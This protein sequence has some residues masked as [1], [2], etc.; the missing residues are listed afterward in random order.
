MAHPMNINK[1]LSPVTPV[2]DKGTH[3]PDGYGD[4]DGDFIWAQ[5]HRLTFTKTDFSHC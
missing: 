4:S 2:I 1:P 5:Q 3:G